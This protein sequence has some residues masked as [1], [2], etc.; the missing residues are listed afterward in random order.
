[1]KNLH[2][3]IER[4][5]LQS[6]KTFPVVYIAGPRQSGKTTLV[7]HITKTKHKAHYFTFDDLQTRSAAKNDPMAFLN[8]LEG[9]VVIDEVQMAP[10]IFRPLKIIVD[11]NRE[12]RNKGRGRFL[13][14]GSSNIMTLPKL[15]DALVGR[16]AL[17]TLYPFSASE[18]SGTQ[19]H[20]IEK[21]LSANWTFKKF[22]PLNITKILKD[23]SYP[24]LFNV[25]NQKFNHEWCNS[26]LNTILQRDVRMLMEVDKISSLPDMLHLFGTRTGGLL[27]EASIARNIDLN[28]LTVKKYRILLENLFLIL[29]I[30]PW[31]H[32]LGKRLIKAPKIYLAD[33]NLLS[34]LLNIDIISLSKNN[35]MLFGSVLETFVAIELSKQLSF[36]G[37]RTKLYHYRTSSGQEVDFIL[38]GPEKKICAIEVKA[39][40]HLT[41]RD[42]RHLIKLQ[43]D[44]GQKMQS[45][46]VIYNGNQI[47]VF[48]DSLYAI[49]FSSL[50]E[51]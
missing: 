27:N 35:P 25:N 46:L 41:R 38:E 32:N 18:I 14:T 48:G 11:K 31:S 43:A 16:M 51:K 1:M 29:S 22:K 34:Y 17:H 19:S 37:V 39:T 10:E 49:P 40:S 6:L 3:H 13:L 50:W 9:N 30:P 47:T 7:R 33:I 15:S 4:K 2:R 21:A 12:T 42:F 45:G 24:E 23:S 44:L 5:I 8:A 26:Y 28:H 36:S 20:F